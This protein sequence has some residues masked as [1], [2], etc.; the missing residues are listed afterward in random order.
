MC[1]F[2]NEFSENAEN[3]FTHRYGTHAEN[4]VLHATE[5]FR[6]L[7]SLGQIVEGYLLIIPVQHYRAIADLPTELYREL[8]TVISSTRRVLS[9][10]YGPAVLFE[11]GIRGDEAGGCGVEHA[12]LHII[13]FANQNELFA[14][15]KA[16]HPFTRTPSVGEHSL[17]VSSNAPYLY[18]EQANGNAWMC[19][20]ERIES[21]YVRKI[22]AQYAGM[23]TWD[24][25]ESGQELSLL[26]TISRLTPLFREEVERSRIDNTNRRSLAAVTA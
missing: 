12:H 9:M 3:S 24:W 14:V 26:Q 1:D 11:H 16:N 8:T 2:C 5:N 15:L 22:I 17:Q 7:P 10:S 13:P 23:A 20:I 25:R 18:Y 21:Q 6:V 4:R 19:E